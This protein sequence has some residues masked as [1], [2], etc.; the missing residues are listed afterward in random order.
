MSSIES[1]RRNNV[2]A[3]GETLSHLRDIR[4]AVTRP[5]KRPL[6]KIF[7]HDVRYAPKPFDRQVML[8]QAEMLAIAGGDYLAA[9]AGR[10][11]ESTVLRER[12]L[13]TLS[14]FSNTYTHLS[15][16]SG[17]HDSLGNASYWVLDHAFNVDRD[18]NYITWELLIHNNGGNALD[19]SDL[20]DRKT[21]VV[22]PLS[23]DYLIA[24]IFRGYLDQNQ[25]RTFDLYSIAL[26]I[27]HGITV[28]DASVFLGGNEFAIYID[29]VGDGQTAQA[30]YDS[31]QKMLPDKTIYQP[32]NLRL[33]QVV[34]T[35]EWQSIPRDMP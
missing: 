15:P 25:G 20:I 7:K 27:N 28:L 16:L 10:N 21:G 12:W 19:V 8:V 14:D 17:N 31:L 23:S 9:E 13:D 2:S 30:T 4:S 11:G 29:G 24:A 5:E 35:F 34:P 3:V 26:G 6:R 22:A 18:P 32:N 33:D 1:F